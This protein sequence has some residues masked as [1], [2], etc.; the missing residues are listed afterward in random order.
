MQHQLAAVVGS[1]AASSALGEPGRRGQYTDD[2]HRTRERPR[3][4]VARHRAPLSV[5]KGG[6]REQ[7]TKLRRSGWGDRAP[8]AEIPTIG[9]AR[10]HVPLTEEYP[11]EPA[12]NLQRGPGRESK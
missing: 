4:T 2:Q 5:T 8:P 9:I 11:A 1:R 6:V 7:S 12:C 3:P 10:W